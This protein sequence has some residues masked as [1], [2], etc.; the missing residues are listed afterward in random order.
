[1]CREAVADKVTKASEEVYIALR[2]LPNPGASAAELTRLL[3]ALLSE[4]GRFLEVVGFVTHFD[5][6]PVCH[7]E[8]GEDEYEI[9][10]ANRRDSRVKDMLLSLQNTPKK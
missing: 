6:L 1:M 4:I 8:I 10:D 3:P 2:Q 7:Q 5:R 9:L